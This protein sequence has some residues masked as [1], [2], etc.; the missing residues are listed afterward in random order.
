M[1]QR[2]YHITELSAQMQKTSNINKQNDRE[3]KKTFEGKNEYKYT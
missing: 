3:K 2:F 1:I